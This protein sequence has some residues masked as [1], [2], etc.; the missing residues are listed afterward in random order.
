MTNIDDMSRCLGQLEASMKAVNDKLANMDERYSETF[1][2]IDTRLSHI[3]SKESERKGAWAV[4]AAIGAV[5]ASLFWKIIPFI[6]EK[7]L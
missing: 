3:E 5:A 1:K 7:I 4:A 2:S 6:M